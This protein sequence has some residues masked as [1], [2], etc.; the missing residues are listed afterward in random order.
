MSYEIVLSDLDTNNLTMLLEDVKAWCSR[1]QMAV[2]VGEMAVGA[3]L[4]A[5]GVHNGTIEMGSQLVATKL[6]GF[7]TASLAGASGGSGMGVAAGYILGSIGVAGMGTAIGIP[8]ALVIGG[9]AAV[10]GMAGYTIGD[11]ADN[12]NNP[13]VDFASFAENGSILLI[14][15]ALLVDGARRFIKDEKV[16]AGLSIVKGSVI[17]LKDITVDIIA[18]TIEELNGFISELRK[19][20][21]NSID[22]SISAGSTGAGA[23]G[24][25]IVGG[26]AA[27]GSV[28]VLG[29]SALGGVAVSLGIVSAPV[30]PVVAGV[31]GGAGLGYSLYKAVKYWGYNPGDKRQSQSTEVDDWNFWS[32]FE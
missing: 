12:L 29:S 2:G 27:A 16:L 4:I 15:V 3:S 6:G 21:E 28:S 14:G 25:A 19:L 5:W 31:A 8:A 7:G 20:P 13:P 10:F 1:S 30:W 32:L 22:A 24:G 23:L 11:I 18:K 9:A 17:F 26:A